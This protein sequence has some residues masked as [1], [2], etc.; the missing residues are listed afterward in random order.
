M[1]KLVKIIHIS[2]HIQKIAEFIYLFFKRISLLVFVEEAIELPGVGGGIGFAVGGEVVGSLIIRI[3]LGSLGSVS[4]SRVSAQV[5][6]GSLSS[7]LRKNYDLI[8]L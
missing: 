4:D 1:A 8:S 5:S 3:Y 7:N 2:K 6:I